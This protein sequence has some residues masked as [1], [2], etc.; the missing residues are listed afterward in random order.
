MVVPLGR[1]ARDSRGDGF[2]GAPITPNRSIG[3]RHDGLDCALRARG[4]TDPPPMHHPAFRDSLQ[5]RVQELER[6]QRTVLIELAAEDQIEVLIVMERHLQRAR[7]LDLGVHGEPPVPG[8]LAF[9]DSRYVGDCRHPIAQS[10]DR[11]LDP[12]TNCVVWMHVF[13]AR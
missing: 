10:L 12:G 7:T 3:E 8:G 5:E 4:T 6:G 13:Q 1:L 9:A 2:V 11:G